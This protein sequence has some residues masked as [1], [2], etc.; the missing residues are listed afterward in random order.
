MC[1]YPSFRTLIQL[2]GE[3]TVRVGHFQDQ[4]FQNL[5]KIMPGTPKRGLILQGTH[6]DPVHIQ[7]L[8]PTPN[9]GPPK[10]NKLINVV[11]A[12]TSTKRITERY[13]HILSLNSAATWPS[14][15]IQGAKI[16]HFQLKNHWSICWYLQRWDY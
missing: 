13:V 14:P 10:I 16:H 11:V 2:G 7:Y 8:Y 12:S 15:R 1:K 5:I 3:S 4:G 9:L 6:Q